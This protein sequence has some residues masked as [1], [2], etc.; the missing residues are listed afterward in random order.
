MENTRRIEVV[1][2]VDE[3]LNE[4][5]RS[6]FVGRLQDCDGVENACFTP[7]HNNL[8]LVDYDRDR[9]NGMDLL[10]YVREICKA[11]MTEPI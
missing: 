2:H 10:G 5:Q 4:D 7:D 6:D 11:E 1:V 9:L 3:T 8:L